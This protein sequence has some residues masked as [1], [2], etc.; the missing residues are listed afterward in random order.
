MQWSTWGSAHI[1]DGGRGSEI[2]TSQQ[3][4]GSDG[5]QGKQTTSRG[6][7]SVCIKAGANLATGKK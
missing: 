5:N 4:S 3:S 2:K 1:S 7:M 6:S